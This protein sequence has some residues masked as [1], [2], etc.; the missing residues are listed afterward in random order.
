MIFNSLHCEPIIFTNTSW[1]RI[2]EFGLDFDLAVAV[3]IGEKKKD[4]LQEVSRNWLVVTGFFVSSLES[5]T[6]TG[7][8]PVAVELIQHSITSAGVSCHSFSIFGY[9]ANLC[10]TNTTTN[11]V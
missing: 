2:F 6:D 9:H 1:K 4:T 3:S 11:E 8:L 7:A 5:V 10:L